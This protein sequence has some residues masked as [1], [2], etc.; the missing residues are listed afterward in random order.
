MSLHRDTEQ[1]NEVHDEDWPEHWYVEQ[2]EKRAEEGDGGGL[3]GGVPELELRQSPDERPELLVLRGGQRHAVLLLLPVILRHGRVDLGG[4]EG[5][6]KVEV[7]DGECVRDDIPSLN[8]RI[9]TIAKLHQQQTN[10]PEL[11]TLAP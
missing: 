2:L 10:K 11:S 9:R 6:Q 1:G 7:I 8:K 4:E 5:Q 3:S